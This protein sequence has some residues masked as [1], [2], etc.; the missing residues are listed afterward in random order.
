LGFSQFEEDMDR[1]RVIDSNAFIFQTD[2]ATD[3]LIFALNAL[4]QWSGHFIAISNDEMSIY[5]TP[6]EY[7]SKAV[8]NNINVRLR[9]PS[10]SLE[11]TKDN[12]WNFNG[13]CSAIYRKGMEN[14]SAS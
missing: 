14:S 5:P 9:V 11:D 6:S 8:N 10:E 4:H 12:K 7:S 1:W 3:P 13:G 2:L